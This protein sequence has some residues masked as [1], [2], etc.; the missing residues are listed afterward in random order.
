MATYVMSDLHGCEKEF[1]EILAKIAFSD[2]DHLVMMLTP[3][4]GSDGE[5]AEAEAPL[6]LPDRETIGAQLAVSCVDARLFELALENSAGAQAATIMA[7][8]SA[9][10][11]AAESAAELEITINRRRQAE[12]TSS[13]IE[14]AS[15][16]I[17]QGD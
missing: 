3:E 8:R 4:T 11:N 9:C 15:G 5:E 2:A 17:H 12:V 6:F 14:T 13:V 16:S 7:M 1:K 10:D